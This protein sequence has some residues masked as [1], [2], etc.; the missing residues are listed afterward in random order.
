M[1]PTAPKITRRGFFGGHLFME[2]CFGQVWDNSGK[3]ILTLKN[4]PALT[5]MCCTTTDF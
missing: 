3:M 5:H 4:L 2:Y 1:A